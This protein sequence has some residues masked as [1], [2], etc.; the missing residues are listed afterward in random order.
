MHYLLA[1]ILLLST[2]P[3]KLPPG[4]DALVQLAN[5]CP[6]E[7]AAD[8]LLRIAAVPSVDK[9]LRANLID[10]AFHLAAAAQLPYRRNLP[11]QQPDTVTAMQADA[12][13][14]NLDTLS[15]E[16]RAVTEMAAIDP[17]AA[18]ELFLAIPIP[19]P[20]CDGP[21]TPDFYAIKSLITTAPLTREERDYY[22]ARAGAPVPACPDPA[23]DDKTNSL[24]QSDRA[25]EIYQSALQLRQNAKAPDFSQRLTD[26]QNELSGWTPADETSESVYYHEKCLVFELLTDI[27]PPGAD[28]DRILQSLVDFIA[29]SPLQRE[30]PAEWFTHA[31]DLAQRTPSVIPIFETSGSPVLQLYA[32][33]TNPAKS[34]SSPPN[35]LPPQAHP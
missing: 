15:L 4:L 9:K 29:N 2:A 19:E 20:A 17:K 22:A 3:P 21:L 11:K 35:P 24:W 34:Q 27:T 18:R 28:R 16:A 23:K 26:F 10:Q 13:K 8:A 31:Q 30:K 32:R 25:K 6:P 5:A 33:L 14:L 12:Y 1:A 7:F